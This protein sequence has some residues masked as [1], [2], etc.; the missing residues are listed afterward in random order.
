MLIGSVIDWYYFFPVPTPYTDDFDLS[1][2]QKSVTCL[3][4]AGIPNSELKDIFIEHDSSIG[5]NTYIYL[6]I[7]IGYHTTNDSMRLNM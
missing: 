5:I 2:K 7:T 4:W 1:E 6:C 3:I